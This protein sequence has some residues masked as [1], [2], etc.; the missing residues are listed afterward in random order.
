MKAL[1][2]RQQSYKAVSSLFDSLSDSSLTWHLRFT[3]KVAKC[4]ILKILGSKVL[5]FVSWRFYECFPF[6]YFFCNVFESDWKLESTYYKRFRQQGSKSDSLVLYTCSSC[7]C[8]CF[9]FSFTVTWR[10]WHLFDS[11][12]FSFITIGTVQSK[13]YRMRK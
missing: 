5:V 2:L 1:G 13:N 3:L 12:S 9:L 4:S 8:S 11:L 7:F 6:F 10:T